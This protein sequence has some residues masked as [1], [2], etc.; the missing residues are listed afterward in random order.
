MSNLLKARNAIQQGDS[1]HKTAAELIYRAIR[2]GATRRIVATRVGKSAAWVNRLLLWRK[3]GYK[4]ET[5]F[6]PENKR[7]RQRER[8]RQPKRK[9]DVQLTE[10]QSRFASIAA[11]LVA[12]LA[13]EAEAKAADETKTEATAKE[14]ER[15]GSEKLD[16]LSR[17]RLIKL[18]NARLRSSG[19]AR[20]RGEDGRRS[21]QAARADVGPTNR[22]DRS[23]GEGGMRRTASGPASVIWR[24]AASL[25]D[26]GTWPTTS[27]TTPSHSL[28]T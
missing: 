27:P 8:Q 17:K 24:G 5:V 15:S 21:A 12:Q 25:L 7:K 23:H 4:D 6:G 2:M 18:R 20:Q 13:D 9:P 19:R 3:A 14:R 1:Y 10:Q 26:F 22:Q 28:W 16:E 11:E